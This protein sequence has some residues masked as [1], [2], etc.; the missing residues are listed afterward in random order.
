MVPVPVPLT[1]SS[2][3]TEEGE[4]GQGKQQENATP[5]ANACCDRQSKRGERRVVQQTTKQQ[6]A[7]HR[8]NAPTQA[9]AS[10]AQHG[11]T[12]C[13]LVSGLWPATNNGLDTHALSNQKKILKAPPPL[14]SQLKSSSV[15]A[16]SVRATSSLV[17]FFE[18]NQSPLSRQ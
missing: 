15:P 17:I 1:V 13:A 7:A 5:Q 9:R 3:E 16:G 4:R 18:A 11:R 10:A 14:I 6:R 8:Q 2:N 12:P